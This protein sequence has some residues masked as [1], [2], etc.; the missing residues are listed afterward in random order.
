MHAY[1]SKSC[2]GD[3]FISA[4]RRSEFSARSTLQEEGKS[5]ISVPLEDIHLSLH[6]LTTIPLN[7]VGPANFSFYSSRSIM[8]FSP[9]LEGFTESLRKEMDP[10]WNIQATIVEPGGFNTNWRDGN[11]RVLPPHP[12]YT[13][14]TS[15]A[16]QYRTMLAG[17]P[18]IG[19]PEKAAKAFLD[20]AEEKQD[21][22]LRVQFGS[23]ALAVIRHT[24]MKTI[25]DS[26][27]WESI[28]H[29]TSN[30]DG[31]DPKEYTMNLLAA[32]G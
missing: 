2:S 26:E 5:S 18:F 16:K 3:Q 30:L 31:I 14:D 15:P 6:F 17:L 11:M 7:L 28:S 22:P 10:E 13:A 12:D 20:L 29:S 27:K 32:L 24:A 23:D 4:R 19:D 21:L 9:A 25:S 1:S 8:D